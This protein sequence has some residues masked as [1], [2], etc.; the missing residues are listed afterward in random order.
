[1]NGPEPKEDEK[2]DLE[3]RVRECERLVAERKPVADIVKLFVYFLF[4][5]SIV[6]GVFGWKKFADIDQLVTETV[7]LRLPPDSRKFMNYKELIEETEILH[8]QFEQLFG[9]Y[10]EALRNYEYI[11]KIAADY[12]YDIE[13]RCTLVLVE[14][15]DRTNREIVD[16]D[17]SGTLYEESWR[18]SAI[19]TLRALAKAQKT[20]RFD[21]DAIFNAAQVCAR[22]RQ[23]ELALELMR[24]AYDKNPDDSPIKARMLSQIVQIESGVE[25]E[26]ALAELMALV[27]SLDNKDPHIVLA[28]ALNAVEDKRRYDDLLH[29]IDACIRNP[30]SVKPSYLY[31]IQAKALLRKSGDHCIDEAKVAVA[32]AFEALSGESVH[33]VWVE[34]ART[35]LPQVQAWIAMSELMH[36]SASEGQ[37][38]PAG[39]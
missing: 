21:S 12:E 10:G 35:E 16:G 18:A 8:Q 25:M 4:A 30:R 3:K 11:D 29:A 39:S 31:V 34:S 38:L 1:M 22:L 19:A 27:R 9:Q 6:L 26:S 14:S 23:D 36:E 32:R 17:K 5:L 20:R 24:V 2:Q 15:I 7:G 33:G 37:V 13:S 28:E